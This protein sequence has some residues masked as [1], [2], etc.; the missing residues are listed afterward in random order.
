M[1][2]QRIDFI[3]QYSRVKN[4]SDKEIT[5]TVRMLELRDQYSYHQLW[6]KDPDI[7]QLTDEEKFALT[8]KAQ[9][10]CD[11]LLT[12]KTLIHLFGGTKYHWRKIG[13]NSPLTETASAISECSS[14]YYGRGWI[15]APHIHTLISF[16]QSDFYKNH[17]F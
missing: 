17:Q 10:S 14:G 5:A 3:R 1:E 16:L 13:R 15:I 8:L 12:T 2:Q 4:L 6:E 11:Y 7:Q 9:D